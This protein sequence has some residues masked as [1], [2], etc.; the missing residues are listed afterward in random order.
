MVENKPRPPLVG[1]SSSTSECLLLVRDGRLA[2]LGFGCWDAL[3]ILSLI[4]LAV[5]CKSVG[6][7]RRRSRGD[8]DT[9]GQKTTQ[10]IR[11]SELIRL[12]RSEQFVNSLLYGF[13]FWVD[14]S[15]QHSAVHF[16]TTSVCIQDPISL[17]SR[18]ITAA[19]AGFNSTS[20]IKKKMPRV[21]LY[22]NC[23]AGEDEKWSQQDGENV[24]VDKELKHILWRTF[25][26]SKCVQTHPQPV[27]K[28]QY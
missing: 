15:G 2:R 22:A 3:R 21:V 28:R 6:Q 14:L 27:R 24:D 12:L 13:S 11:C 18:W 7:R 1:V 4:V 9:E 25:W 26:S 17:T 8:T 16:L 19:A 10:A 5:T 20:T 23:R